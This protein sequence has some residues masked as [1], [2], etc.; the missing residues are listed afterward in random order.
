MDE[1]TSTIYRY[2]DKFFLYWK[3]AMIG[4]LLSAKVWRSVKDGYI[5]PK[6]VRT[7]TQRKQ[8]EIMH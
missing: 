2:D 3:A 6:W 1:T 5:P 7:A 4:R 8:K